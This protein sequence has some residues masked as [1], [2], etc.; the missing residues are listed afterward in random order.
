M[1][2]KQMQKTLLVGT[3]EGTIISVPVVINNGN[4]CA[5]PD[6]ELDKVQ[7]SWLC[8]LNLHVWDGNRCVNCGKTR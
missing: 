1:K 8:R 6:F 2:G 5:D 4:I 7:R 3:Y